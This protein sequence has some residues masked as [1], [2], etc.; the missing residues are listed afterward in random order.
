LALHVENY[1]L[2]M[3]ILAPFLDSMGVADVDFLED[4][5]EQIKSSRENALAGKYDDAISF[6]EGYTSQHACPCICMHPP[7]TSRPEQH[8]KELDGVKEEKFSL[9]LVRA[10]TGV[11]RA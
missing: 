7:S 8:C 11:V 6:Y 9:D 2:K 4:F 5:V 3:T 1:V 10:S